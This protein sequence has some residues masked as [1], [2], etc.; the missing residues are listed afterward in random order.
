[1]INVQIIKPSSIISS[2][3]K[4]GSPLN[5]PNGRRN[6]F[7][8]GNKSPTSG[9][10]LY[11]LKVNEPKI[12]TEKKKEPVKIQVIKVQKCKLILQYL[13][14]SLILTTIISDTTV[15]LYYG[16]INFFGMID[17]IAIL[18]LVIRLI[19]LCIKKDNFY[20]KTLSIIIAAITPLGFFLK[21]FS[22]AYCL[23]NEKVELL[24]IYGTLIG[25][26]TF[27]LIWLLPFTCA[28]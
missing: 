27:G 26:R 12:L 10:S 22:M 18:F 7:N 1:M 6:S 17:N 9:N 11:Y 21:G 28:Y 15:Q 23:M 24:V 4:S 3:S 25:I 19:V 5:S 2:F 16:F 20:C 8:D 13:I 14:T